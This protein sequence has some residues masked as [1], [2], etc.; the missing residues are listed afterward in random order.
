MGTENDT[1]Q[2]FTELSCADKLRIIDF[3]ERLQEAQCNLPHAAGSH[4][5]ATPI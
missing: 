1:Y 4:L 5:L 2:Q 3:A